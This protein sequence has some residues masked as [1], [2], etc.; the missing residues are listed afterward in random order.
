MLETL[1]D[2]DERR[3]KFQTLLKSKPVVGTVL[4][5]K[6]GLAVPVK[7]DR[8]PDFGKGETRVMLVFAAIDRD[9]TG[10]YLSDDAQGL[11]CLILPIS[12]KELVNRFRG[13]QDIEVEALRVVGV[14]DRGTAL[15]CEL[16]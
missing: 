13:E 1:M 6:S 14:N 16:V 2:V 4:R 12:Q 3:D 7:V 11:V 5:S 15:K 8:K 9:C 10:W